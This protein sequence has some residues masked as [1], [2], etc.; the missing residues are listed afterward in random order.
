M[1][2]REFE[3]DENYDGYEGFLPNDFEG[4]EVEFGSIE[5]L[6]HELRQADLYFSQVNLNRKILLDSIKMLKSSWFWKFTKHQTKLK[7]IAETYKAFS[8]LVSEPEDEE[9]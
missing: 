3:D 1:R 8:S 2:Y 9:E 5:E 6:S 4:E 7:R